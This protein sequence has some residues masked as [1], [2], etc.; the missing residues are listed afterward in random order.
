MPKMRRWTPR[1]STELYLILSSRIIFTFFTLRNQA[2][3][4]SCP[5]CLAHFSSMYQSG[6]SRSCCRGC[7]GRYRFMPFGGGFFPRTQYSYALRRVNPPLFFR[8]PSLSSRKAL[9]NK[10]FGSALDF[11][12]SSAGTGD[13]AI[14]ETI[15][16]VKTFKNF[17]EQ[18]TN[19]ARENV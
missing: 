13:Y 19:V 18:V 2:D 8:M 11:V 14:R 4:C 6:P 12:W 16:R 10:A 7:Y 15:T 9:R 5:G 3:I 17:K 1:F